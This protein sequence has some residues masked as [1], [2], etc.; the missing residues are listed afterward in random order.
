VA[1]TGDGGQQI[2]EIVCYP[3]GQQSDCLH[4]LRLKKLFLELFA[5]GYIRDNASESNYFAARIPN[6]KTSGTNLTVFTIRSRNA[7]FD[8]YI[9]CVIHKSC[10]GL[11]HTLTILGHNKIGPCLR[12]RVQTVDWTA[13]DLLKCRAYV[14]HLLHVR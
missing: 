12:D 5:F 6:L 10:I 2:V 13:P 3:A 11:D 9:S 7:I 14:M 8:V 1:V 4:F